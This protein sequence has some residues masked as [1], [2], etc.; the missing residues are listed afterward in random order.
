M[1]ALYSIVGT[2]AV[3]GVGVTC[4]TAVFVGWIAVVAGAAEGEGVGAELFI[5]TV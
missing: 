5:T 1:F 2:G 4:T 3:D